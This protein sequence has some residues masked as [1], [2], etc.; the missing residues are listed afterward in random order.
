MYSDKEKRLDKRVVDRY[1][2]KGLVSEK[3]FEK[4]MKELPDEEVNAEWVSIGM[5]EA[6]LSD[7]G[8][9]NGK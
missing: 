5:D 6:E 1:L 2:K 7:S 9:S 8:Y 4:H 3:E